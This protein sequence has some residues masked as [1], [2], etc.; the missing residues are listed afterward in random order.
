MKPLELK[1]FDNID[2]NAQG[3]EI[4]SDSTPVRTWCTIP[5][6]M[7]DA[8]T[9]GKHLTPAECAAEYW[10][11]TRDTWEAQ[12]FGSYG[13]LEEGWP[14]DAGDCYEREETLERFAGLPHAAEKGYE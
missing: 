9:K 5:I 8:L 3:W 13:C 7:A 6:G 4:A 10:R 12:E 11:A 2:R 14:N 1:V